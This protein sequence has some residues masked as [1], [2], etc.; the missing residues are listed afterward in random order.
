MQTENRTFTVDPNI[1]QHLIRSQAGTLGK[2]FVECVMNAMDAGATRVDIEVNSDGYVIADD[3][4]GF[5]TREEVLGCF[6][7]F[8]FT[9]DD[10]HRD[11]GR[12]GLGRA[13]SWN[14]AATTW[15]TRGF[16]LVVDI[17]AKGL[18]YTL[19][20]GLEDVPG[21]RIEGTFY[22]PLKEVEKHD[23]MC[24][25]ETLC[26]FAVIPVTLNGRSLR[27]D[28]DAAKWTHVS[29]DAYIKVSDS[30]TLSVYNQ[31]VFVRDYPAQFC[32]I[33]GTLVTK[34][35]KVLELNMSRSD[36]LTHQCRLWESLRKEMKALGNAAAATS[37]KKA[38]LTESQ[39]D[40]LAAESADPANLG[41]LLEKLFEFTNGRFGS[42]AN[43]TSCLTRRDSILTVAERGNQLADVALQEHSAVVLTERTLT[44][45]GVETATQLV[46]L[47]ADRLTA[48]GPRSGELVTHGYILRGALRDGR[49][50]DSFE[51]SPVHRRLNASTV[52]VAQ[53][54][55]AEGHVLAAASEVAGNIGYRVR[56]AMIENDLLPEDA[57]FSA[58]RRTLSVGISETA[59]AFTDGSTYIAISRETLAKVY[60]GDLHEMQRLIAI[61]VHEFIHDSSSVETHQHDHQFFQTYHDVMLSDGGAMFALGAQAFRLLCTRKARLTRKQAKALDV[62][63]IGV[64]AG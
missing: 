12:F 60:A 47:L 36:V 6:E 33:G 9:H 1:I 28:P 22:T 14:W 58:R 61:L 8:G 30:A 44:R 34:L 38:R 49:V 16:Q 43:I 4:H 40:F 23:L 17:R 48:D 20:E 5:R 59:E 3:G 42:L 29:D 51:S 2:A 21:L 25:M 63:K 52:P 57:L 45:F 32:G 15:R 18:D 53:W 37:S 54:T 24:E 56:K 64:R 13:Q 7:V 10:R 27:R 62:A 50:H 11:F 35:G 39:R 46:K 55:A 41:N 19:A 26:R 31:G